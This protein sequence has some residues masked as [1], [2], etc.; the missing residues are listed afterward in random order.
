MTRAT[1]T[2]RF[3]GRCWVAR[4]LISGRAGTTACAAGLPEYSLNSHCSADREAAIAHR[5]LTA[6]LPPSILPSTGRS[7]DRHALGAM[8]KQLRR[9]PQ[10]DGRPNDKRRVPM[11]SQNWR[12][13]IWSRLDQPWDIIVI[14]G[15]ITGAGILREA[16]R[17]GLRV[18]LVEQRDFA[19]GTS[20]RSPRRGHCA[21]DPQRERS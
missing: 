2:T 14:G 11:W 15:G 3:T 6:R 10:A 18:L 1:D 4:K 7:A 16:S 12:D 19:W 20:S 13:E 17:A 5:V 9:V 8:I 21:A